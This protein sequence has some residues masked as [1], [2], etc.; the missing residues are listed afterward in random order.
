MKKLAIALILF[1]S[2]AAVGNT[3]FA[4]VRIG[5]VSVPRLLAEAPQ[6]KAATAAIKSEQDS[7]R[8]QLQSQGQQLV[9][10]QKQLQRDF[11]A[12]SDDQKRSKLEE[13][14]TKRAALLEKEN[15]LLGEYNKKRNEKLAELQK[16]L[17]TQVNNLAKELGYDMVF[18]EGVLY[19]NP[20]LDITD[21]VL[22]RLR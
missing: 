22:A 13:I 19:A 16:T 15:K 9:D 3:A 2:L 7:K 18:G 4:E 5:Y 10:L 14:N 20:S 1:C 17:M 12:L 11:D 21:K 8:A 6:A